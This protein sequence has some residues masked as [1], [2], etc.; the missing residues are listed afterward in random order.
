MDKA[1]S[2]TSQIYL[3]VCRSEA[4]RPRTANPASIPDPAPTTTAII[5][6][7][8]ND[9]LSKSNGPSNCLI[10]T[11]AAI[12]ARSPTTNAMFHPTR[13]E[14]VS[15]IEPQEPAELVSI[16][17]GALANLAIRI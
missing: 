17:I 12:S 8:T 16:V 5:E 3:L 14:Q 2:T 10:E 1:R 7:K 6:A 11:V 15:A 9:G 4:N 13:I